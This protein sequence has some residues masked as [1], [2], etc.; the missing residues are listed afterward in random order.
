MM[1][2]ALYVRHTGHVMAVLTR[3]S[4][5]E[6]PPAVAPDKE[7]EAQAAEVLAL[8]GEVLVARGF[9]DRTA[10][11]KPALTEYS[12]AAADL[13]PITLDLDENALSSPRTL[14]ADPDAKE[15]K[16]LSPIW[17][18]V[19]SVLPSGAG[20][21]VTVRLPADVTVETKVWVHVTGANGVAGEGKRFLDSFMPN[22]P[23]VREITL[24]LQPPITGTRHIL[25]L[26][27][28]ARPLLFVG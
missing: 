2:T 11:H 6:A 19:T 24:N 21:S 20:D 3:S 16:A 22:S 4:M 9:E 23:N 14:Y 10:P 13:A 28:G 27:A 25:V 15:L 17:T 18:T 5:T 8:A 7:K 26:L 1:M 12:I